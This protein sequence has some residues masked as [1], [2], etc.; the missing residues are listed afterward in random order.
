MRRKLLMIG[1]PV[2]VVLAVAGFAGWWFVLRDDAPAAVQGVEEQFA[3]SETTT[4]T[5]SA[6]STTP[7][8]NTASSASG[9]TTATTAAATTTAAPATADGT[10]TVQPSERVFAGYRIEEEFVSGALSSTAV[11]RSPA[12]TGTIDID[13]STVTAALVGVDLTQLTSDSDQRDSRIRGGGLETNTFP[14]ATFVL[15]APLDLGAVPTVGQVFTVAAAGDLTLHGV[16]QPI[17]LPLEARWA[18]DTIDLTGSVKIVLAD[19]GISMEAF[20]GFVS[21][22]DEGTMELAVQFVR[23]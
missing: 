2:L 18:G 14:T 4:A 3:S 13:A 22:A 20:A 16:T 21:V 23:A 17:S 6:A 15:T 8:T 19:Y 10:W 12:V 1:V 11:G 5:T 9:A 7:A